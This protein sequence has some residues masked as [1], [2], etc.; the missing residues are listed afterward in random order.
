MSLDIQI[1]DM[2][3]GRYV[4]ISEVNPC[5]EDVPIDGDTEDLEPTKYYYLR[6][7]TSPSYSAGKTSAD[8]VTG[9]GG[10][11][12]AWTNDELIGKV[13]M[14]LSGPYRSKCY[15]ITDNDANTIQ[16]EGNQASGSSAPLL[17][18]AYY[19]VVHTAQSMYD[20]CSANNYSCISIAT[21]NIKWTNGSPEKPKSYADHTTFR[22][23]TGKF[24]Q[25]LALGKCDIWDR[26]PLTRAWKMDQIN[27]LVY[28]W[29]KINN[30]T[31]VY[32]IITVTY[33]ING[34]TYYQNKNF[35][36]K[37]SGSE[38]INGR[39][40]LKGFPMKSDGEM[41]FNVT[42]GINF[43]EAWTL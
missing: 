17:Q 11:S 22:I 10:V 26:D 12:P 37:Y 23:G 32:L 20:F 25:D 40:Y 16:V 8:F 38:V 41:D 31:A 2:F 18:N 3:S 43:S 34:V 6:C 19:T 7:S 14:A 13:I 35:M 24:D 30:N 28:H 29:H 39:G 33:N 36:Y 42:F 21:D 5:S 9:V 27:E 4:I 15:Y 1:D